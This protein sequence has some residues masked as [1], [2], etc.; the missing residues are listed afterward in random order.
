MLKFAVSSQARQLRASKN[1]RNR[2]TPPWMRVGFL[3]IYTQYIAV[4]SQAR[5]L[6]VSKITQQKALCLL[7]AK[8]VQ[9]LKFIRKF[10]VKKTLK[11]CKI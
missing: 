10:V 9:K 7:C 8:K 5:Q 11:H 3:K 4:S 2:E 6:M 1:N